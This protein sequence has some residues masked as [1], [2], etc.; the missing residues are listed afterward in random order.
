MLKLTALATH[1]YFEFEF[2]TFEYD[3]YYNTYN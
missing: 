2:R 3:R 1:R